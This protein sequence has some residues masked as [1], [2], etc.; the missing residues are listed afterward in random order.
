MQK[1]SPNLSSSILDCLWIRPH[2]GRYTSSAA[3][4]PELR[5]SL[6]CSQGNA[7]CPISCTELSQIRHTTKTV[8]QMN[9]TSHPRQTHSAHCDV[10]VIL[11]SI[12]FHRGLLHSYIH[13]N[14]HK[15]RAGRERLLFHH[16]IGWWFS[17]KAYIN[18]KT[19]CLYLSAF[20]IPETTYRI[21]GGK[22]KKKKL[23]STRLLVYSLIRTPLQAKY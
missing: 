5:E 6:M 10:V 18:D 1:S 12:L 22:K 19:K 21:S 7:S 4:R 2:A 11:T 8:F 13:I 3:M 17:N 14:A 16:T 9:T 23:E 15:E 20:F